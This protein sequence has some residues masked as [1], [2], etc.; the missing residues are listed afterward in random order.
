MKKQRILYNFKIIVLSISILFSGSLFAQS[1]KTT[2]EKS[3]IV[4]TKEELNSFLS[5]I[6]EARRS[7]LKQRNNKKIKQDLAELRLKYQQNGPSQN[8]DSRYEDISNS[9]ILRELRYINQRIDNLSYNNNYQPSSN[10]DNA[11]II[12]PGSSNAMSSYAQKGSSSTTVIPSNAK[13]IKE[14]EA[15]IDSLKNEKPMAETFFKDDSYV[16]SLR[17][18]KDRL[19]NVKRQMDDLLLKIN[20]TEKVVKSKE[21]EKNNT[22]FKQQ[23]Y[24]SNNSDSL[25]PE[26][27]KY[28]QDLTQILLEYPEA[29]VI[30]EG[31]ASQKGN[32][33]YNKKL[34]MRRADAVKN[35][36][37]NNRIDASR[38]LTSFKGEDTI[39]SEQHA[40]RVDMSIVV[41]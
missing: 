12:I 25:E 14:L 41:K 11:T 36:F 6:A 3:T 37:I 24:F 33:N 35:A 4:M 39:S 1:E 26:Y 16:D 20:T 38:I 18:M 21:I 27:Y 19:K 10:R 40:R 34:S 2:S 8:T 15:K 31:W 17:V 7:Q 23:V 5:T 30:L 32:S 29:K 13:K 28:I 9:Q 22:Y